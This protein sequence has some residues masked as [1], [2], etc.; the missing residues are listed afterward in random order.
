MPHSSSQTQPK[1]Q[2]AAVSEVS[3]P[4]AGSDP[5]LYEVPA[6]QALSSSK[7]TKSTEAT[8]PLAKTFEDFNLSAPLQQALTAMGFEKP[9]AIQAKAIPTLMQGKDV[10]GLSQTGSGKTA[11]FAIPVIQ[12]LDASASQSVKQIQ[13]VIMC[14]TRELVLQV[15]SQIG[16]LLQTSPHVKVAA[17]YGGEDIRRQ[18]QV[19]KSGVDIVVATP[20]RTIDLMNRQVLNLSRAKTVIL[21]EADE[22]LDMGF[23]D[24]IETVLSQA[25]SACKNRQTVL[26]SATMAPEIL[27]LAKSYQKNPITIDVKHE[28]HSKPNINQHFSV[29]A[30]TAKKEAVFRL[31]YSHSVQC[32]VV[33]CNTK[34]RVDTL[35]EFL[36][37]KN[38]RA[39]ALHGDL[40]QNART[41]IMGAFRSGYFNILVA[42]DVA[43]RGMDV[44]GLEMVINH[45]LPRDTEDYIHR[46]GR[47]GRAGKAGHAFTLVHPRESYLIRRIA[48]QYNVT[49]SPYSIPS[50]VLVEKIR[51]QQLLVQLSEKV[52]ANQGLLKAASDKSLSDLPLFNTMVQLKQFI[53]EGVDPVLLAAT[54]FTMNA[55][56]GLATAD[57]ALDRFFDNSRQIGNPYTEPGHYQDRKRPRNGYN[58]SNRHGRSGPGH[59]GSFSGERPDKSFSS[60]KRPAR[61]NF[62]DQGYAGKSGPR[63]NSRPS[64]T[65]RNS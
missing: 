5:V 32:A 65:E 52:Q 26:F 60:G 12:H 44:D 18:I 30:E 57:E 3:D 46:V 16:Q 51:A 37:Q 24:D 59:Q 33:F 7:S 38:L 50:S 35:V 49:I 56:E 40:N 1:P 23:R 55:E 8:A 53:K 64:F 31:L 9:S 34:A 54:L 13:A 6:R 25:G 63:K 62:S 61:S 28:K 36:R 22:M 47:T 41:R 11:A 17:V 4:A 45:D 27:R 42:T 39:D 48:R 20:G 14:P 58:R 19:L 2:Q 10:I 43:G 29:I 15:S 21:D